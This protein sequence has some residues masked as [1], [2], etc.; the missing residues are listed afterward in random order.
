MGDIGV[1]LFFMLSGASLMYTW[2][3][4]RI[5]KFYIRRFRSIYPMF[6]IAWFVA[7]AV[8]FLSYKGLNSGD[9]RYMLFSVLAWMD[10]FAI[11]G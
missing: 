6:W 3:Q 9:I 4:E 2:R 8:D 5:T 11:R 7:T 1:S 10:I